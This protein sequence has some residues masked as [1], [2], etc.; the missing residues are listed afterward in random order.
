MKLFLQ[1]LKNDSSYS[2]KVSAFTVVKI[3][4]TAIVSD[5]KIARRSL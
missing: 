3:S 2:V 1:F 4:E 5:E